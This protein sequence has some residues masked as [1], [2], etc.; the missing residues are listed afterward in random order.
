MRH[1]FLSWQQPRNL[2]ADAGSEEIGFQ[3]WLASMDRLKRNIA[4]ISAEAN[5][6]SALGS[7]FSRQ[8]GHQTLTMKP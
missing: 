5:L 8:R 3:A 2:L 4:F 6:Q 1:H 7:A